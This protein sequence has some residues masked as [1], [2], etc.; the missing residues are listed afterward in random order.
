MIVVR[1]VICECEKIDAVTSRL[2]RLNG[3]LISQFYHVS[4]EQRF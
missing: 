2:E 4:V 1:G 3:H